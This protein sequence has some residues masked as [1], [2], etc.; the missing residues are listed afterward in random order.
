[1]SGNKRDTLDAVVQAVRAD[2]PA[3]TCGERTASATGPD[4]PRTARRTTRP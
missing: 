3:L 2:A 4:A 1:M